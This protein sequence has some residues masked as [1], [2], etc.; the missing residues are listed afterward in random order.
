MIKYPPLLDNDEK[1]LIGARIPMR[2]RDLL[3]QLG[4]NNLTD[5]IYILV[6]SYEAH[7]KKH[8]DKIS[9]KVKIKKTRKGHAKT[10]K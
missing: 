5:G 7:I 6:H 8:L 4:D 3:Y 2:Y 9:K 1:V 10:N